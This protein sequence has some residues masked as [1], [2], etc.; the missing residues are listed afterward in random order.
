MNHVQSMPR[1]QR[2]AAAKYLAEQNKRWPAHLVHMPQDEWP[3]GMSPK[4]LAVMRSRDYLVQ[5]FDEQKPV[6]VRL[7]INRCAITPAG[8][9]QEDIPWVDLQRLKSEAGYGE[10]DAVEVF[11]N[12]IDVVNVASMRHIF[13]MAEPLSFAWR[14]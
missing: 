9:W 14:K 7:T 5:I 3:P 1:D 10:F 6:L 13:V 11:P 2:R 12:D 8:G 4:L